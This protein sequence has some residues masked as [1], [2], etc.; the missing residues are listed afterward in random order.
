M[1]RVFFLLFMVILVSTPLVAQDAEQSGD[2]ASEEPEVANAAIAVDVAELVLNL[3]FNGAV[4]L[5]LEYLQ[6]S[7][8]AGLGFSLAPQVG[9]AD[10]FYFGAYAG[11]AYYFGDGVSLLHLKARAGVIY[12]GILG[13]VPGYD[14]L[15]GSILFGGDGTDGFALGGEV[16]VADYGFGLSLNWGLKLGYGFPRRTE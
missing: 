6:R 3:V 9:Y 14:I 5:D 8:L 7:P 11:P 10:A 4:G 2:D 13:L 1:K 16:G 15:I 12:S